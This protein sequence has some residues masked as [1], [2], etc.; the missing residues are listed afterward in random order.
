LKVAIQAYELSLQHFNNQEIAETLDVTSRQVS[1]Y[2]RKARTYLGVPEG[3]KHQALA[4]C[5]LSIKLAW[6]Q[7]YLATDPRTKVLWHQAALRAQI[8]RDRLLGLLDGTLREEIK[9]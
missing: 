2:L 6:K 7:F 9:H 1:N 3:L 8:H 5:M 4:E